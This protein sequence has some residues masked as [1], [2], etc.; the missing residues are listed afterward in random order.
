MS[1][2]PPYTC[3]YCEKQIPSG[4]ERCPECRAEL[5]EEVT[6]QSLWP[7]LWAFV[8]TPLMSYGSC[9]FAA[10]GTPSFDVPVRAV[11]IA[12]AIDLLRIILYIRWRKNN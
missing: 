8:L 10:M 1:A 12:G 7:F 6:A 2:A 5:V 9:M 11:Q 3:P 4:R